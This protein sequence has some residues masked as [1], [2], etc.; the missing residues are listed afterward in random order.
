MSDTLQIKALVNNLPSVLSFIDK[1][2]EENGCPPR[3]ICQIDTVAEEIFVN[4]ANYAYAPETGS[5]SVG[6][7]CSNKAAVLT[8]TDQGT[9]YDPFIRSDPDVTL[10]A[11][12]RSIG[13]LGVFMV[14]KMTDEFSYRRE[15]GSNILT[16]KKTFD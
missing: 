8:F 15:N 14:K 12:D 2:L 3:V 5:M 1:K 16:I 6:I 13:G 11:K 4:I 10:S 7:E 9:A